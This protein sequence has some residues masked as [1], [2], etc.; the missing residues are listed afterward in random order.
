MKR[1][2]IVLLSIIL[3]LFLFLKFNLNNLVLILLMISNYFIIGHTIKVSSK[4]NNNKIII[5]SFI[6]SIIYI[7]CDSINKTDMIDIINNRLLLNISG[8][9]ILIYVLLT[10]LFNFLDNYSF[11][12]KN[13]NFF[14]KNILDDSK[15]SFILIFLFIFLIDFIF[16]LKYYPGNLTYDSYNQISQSI[17]VTKLI[18]N[19]PVL[20]TTFIMIFTRIGLL[21][22][23]ISIGV[24][25]YSIVQIIIYSLF[26][27]YVIKIESKYKVNIYIRILTLLLF[28]FHP[29]NIIY[30]FTMWKDI[31]FSIVFCIFS[32]YIYEY[33]KDINFF[34]KK[35]NTILFILLSLLTMYLRNNAVYVVILTLLILTIMD[36]RIFKI[37]ISV[38][39]LYFLSKTI[40]FKALSIDSS[41]AREMFSFPSQSIARIYKYD[42]DSLSENEISLIES[43]YS[44]EVGN[45][46]LSYISDP[47]KNIFNEER[48]KENKLEY[49]KLNIDLLK[50]YPKRYLESFIAGSYGYYYLEVDY[51]SIDIGTASELGVTKKPMISNNVLYI[52]IGIITLFIGYITFINIKNKKNLLYSL[53]LISALLS[54]DLNVIKSSTF[55]NIGFYSVMMLILFIYNIINKKNYKIFIPAF[56]LFL[57][58]LLSPVFSEFRYLYAVFLLFPFYI[59]ISMKDN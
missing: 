55:M 19:H 7:M 43:Y 24:F 13:I 28:M 51:H 59:G 53:L 4:K 42:Y 39:I 29:I 8:Y 14:N 44:N 27:S 20:H 16:L 12:N 17:G 46:Y 32:I 34:N 47:V 54:I 58:I 45:L 48:F 36:R 15:F 35:K 38:F 5:I 10:N 6:F 11:K 1:I 3:S 49:L 41:S 21:F 23:N 50:K 52:F 22:N 31:I 33:N 18:N 56:I 2:I 9:S 57:T 37:F 40:I 25:L 30:S 26:C